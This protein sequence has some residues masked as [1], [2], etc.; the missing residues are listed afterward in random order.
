M[1]VKWSRK[2]L[3]FASRTTLL[4]GTTEPRIRIISLHML[5][6][7]V[8]NASSFKNIPFLPVEFLKHKKIQSK[9]GAKRN[10]VE[11]ENNPES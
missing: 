1:W 5:I 10:I 3:V 2:A 11:L 7:S 4:L 9:M 8:L 6:I